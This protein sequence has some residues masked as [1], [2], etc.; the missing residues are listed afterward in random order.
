V[1]LVCGATGELG[2]RI[3]QRLRAV[4]S[5]VRALVRPH[6]D[7]ASLRRVGAEVVEGDFRDP[8]SLEH[9]VTGIQTVVS[10]VT[11]I[12]RALAGEKDADFQRVDVQ[13]HRDLIAA[14]EHA[15]V[16]RFVFVS[17]AR[18][19]LEPTASTPLGRGKIATEDRLAAS[20]LR[21]VVVRPDQFQ[22]IWLSPLAQFDWPARKV[23]IFGK[24]DTPTRYIA[25]DD[26]A[27]AVVRLTLAEDPPRLVEL[28]GPDPL[29]RNQA[30]EVFE[31][32]LGQ[33]I[34]RRHVPRAAIR[35]GTGALR[36][37]RPG[38]ASVMGGALCADLHPATWDDR[39]LRELGIEPR[40]VE[41]YATAAIRSGSSL[42]G[43]QP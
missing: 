26:V 12:G 19:R 22:E 17:A 23:V 37:F 16:E 43:S 25:I 21:E 15:G 13:G 5:P 42:Q 14:A 36:R 7:A 33:P 9:A 3:V 35:V 41:A 18:V 38:M 34:R 24:G 29:T 27:E 32:A 11:V 6:A 30:V 10:T 20:S 39:P 28:G 2:A 8:E 31:R 4:E 1:I 40:T